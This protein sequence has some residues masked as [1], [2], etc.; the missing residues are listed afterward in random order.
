MKFYKE[1]TPHSF[2]YIY[3]EYIYLVETKARGN[4]LL[5][6]FKNGNRMHKTQFCNYEN[7]TKFVIKLAQIEIQQV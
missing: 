2:I 4:R 6:C 3:K 7:P 1:N 5:V